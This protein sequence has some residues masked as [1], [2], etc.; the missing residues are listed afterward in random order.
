[1][2]AG[3][4]SPPSSGYLLDTNVVSALRV[5]GRNPLVEAWA[6]AIPHQVLFVASLTIAE[7][8]LGIAVKE[9]SDPDQG[10]VLRR[11][12]EDRL[13]PGF[14]GRVLPFDL[15]AARI[16]AT[17]RIPD[18]A[19]LHDA[20]IASTAKAANLTVATRNTAHFAPLG[21]ALVNPW[22]T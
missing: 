8:E 20:V 22:E 6:A 7:I 19:P 12:F 4:G 21:V 1:M 18:R 10:A 14:A 17:Y 2:P 9:R 5:R 13:L 11:W 15:A 3:L 16:L